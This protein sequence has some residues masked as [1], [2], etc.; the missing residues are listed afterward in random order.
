MKQ[1]GIGEVQGQPV[2][3]L[4]SDSLA[5]VDYIIK[6]FFVSGEAEC[7]KPLTKLANDGKWDVIPAGKAKYITRIVVLRPADVAR[8]SGTA[9]VEWVNVTGGLDVPA[10]WLMAHREIVRE[11]HVY[12][13]CSAQRVGI[14]GG[15]SRGPDMSLKTTHPEQYAEL[16]HPGDAFSF[17]IFSQ[18]GR[19]VRKSGEDGVLGGLQPTCILAVGESQSAMFLTTYINAI[20]PLAQVYDGFLIHSRFADAGP[21]DGSSMFASETTQ[22]PAAPRFRSDLRRPTLNLITETDLIG[23]FR[24]GYHLARQPDMPTLRTWE[25]TGTAHA[26]NYLIQ[27]APIDTGSTPVAELAAAFAPTKSLMGAQLRQPINFAPQHHYVLQA[28]LSR[29]HKWARSGAAPPSGEP[30]VLAELLPARLEEDANGVAKGGVRTPWVDVPVAR[31]SGIGNEESAIASL[32]GSGN[33]FDSA[34]FKQLYPGGFE[35]YRARF[36]ISPD[37]AIL[38]GFILLSDRTEI[39]ELSRISYP[40][41]GT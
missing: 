35:D 13:A 41:V 3:A 22:M 33:T 4:R 37:A 21:L 39:L 5:S 27:V 18:V 36:E 20:D 19:V 38:A 9:L 10:E 7:Y 8:F 16:H 15:L 17:D 25:V 1:P 12:V 28:A 14:E 6:E 32:F 26:D 34:T 29:L 11:G 2:L 23:G 24:A 31:T 40:A 30:L